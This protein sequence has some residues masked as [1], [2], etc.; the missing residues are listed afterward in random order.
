LLQR[1][2]RRPSGP[3]I[4]ALAIQNGP[5]RVF[6]KLDGLTSI[7]LVPRGGKLAD[8]LGGLLRSWGEVKPR[9]SLVRERIART[10]QALAES[11]R[12][13]LHLARLWAA[14][15]IGRLRADRQIDAARD[16]AG[17]YQLVTP[18][19]GAVVLETQQQFARHGLTPVDPATVPAIPEPGTWALL[20]LGLAA[21]GIYAR[22]PARFGSKPDP[23][24][25][26]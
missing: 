23:Q 9:L 15:E 21:L 10:T 2:E 14:D 1:Y 8:D 3:R 25:T 20:A 22:R 12:T 24:S 4:L 19:S 17:R 26:R 7:A 18:V 11:D 16:L 6:E 5:N 13:S